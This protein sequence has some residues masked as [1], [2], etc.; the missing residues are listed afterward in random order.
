MGGH[1]HGDVASRLA[2][3]VDPRRRWAGEPQRSSRRIWR[4]EMTPGSSHGSQRLTQG[5]PSEPT[6]G[7]CCWRS[8]T[9]TSRS[10]AW[11]LPLV[12]SVLV[13]G[14]RAT[15]VAHVGDSR[16]YR[17]SVRTACGL[18]T[19]RPHLGSRTGH[20]RQ[21]VRGASALPP[22]QECGHPCSR[23]RSRGRA[24]SS[25]R[26]ELA[27]GDRLSCCAPTAS[28]EWSA[29]DRIRQRL[30]EASSAG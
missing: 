27:P 8:K 5:A 23:R 13:E 7:M 3:R 4:G 16:A 17:L 21:P 24:W 30:A 18:L 25:A 2:V 15:W 22:V 26:V 19:A 10:P 29:D 11:A 20:R 28:P 1:G 6:I 12:V 9:R 14:C